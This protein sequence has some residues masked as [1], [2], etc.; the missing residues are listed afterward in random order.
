LGRVVVERE[1]SSLDPRAA[2]TVAAVPLILPEW[3]PT[4][5][6]VFVDRSIVELFVDD[7]HYLATRVYPTRGDSRGIGVFCEAGAAAIEQ[8]VV[9]Q[10]E[11]I[12]PAAS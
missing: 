6:R 10:E 8:L 11:T 2:S 4:A 5:C 9:W 1:R 7:R 12:W 3:E